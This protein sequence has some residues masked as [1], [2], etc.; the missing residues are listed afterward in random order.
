MLEMVSKLKLK[1]PNPA[2]IR[3]C[4]VVDGEP[5]PAKK[6]TNQSRARKSFSHLKQARKLAVLFL[7]K[8]L[9][10]Q[11]NVTQKFHAAF[12]ACAFGWLRWFRDIKHLLVEELCALGVSSGFDPESQAEYSVVTA[13]TRLRFT[14]Y[15][16]SFC[17]HLSSRPTATFLSIH[18]QTRPL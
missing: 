5:L 18:L 3:S 17:L 4:F 2:S 1:I 15:T 8:P 6:S 12:K 11:A 16:S 7:G 10:E 14:S 9:A 13:R